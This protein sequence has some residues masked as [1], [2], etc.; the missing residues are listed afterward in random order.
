M[1]LGNIRVFWFFLEC[2]VI[3]SQTYFV[4]IRSLLCLSA[5]KVLC[6]TSA[7]YW[8][9]SKFQ[10][11]VFLFDG[12]KMIISYKRF[13]SYQY[14]T[15]VKIKKV[16]KLTFA[17]ADY[18]CIV[19]RIRNILVLLIRSTT[20]RKNTKHFRT[21]IHLIMNN[22]ALNTSFILFSLFLVIL[23]SVI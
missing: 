9:F 5:V 4:N 13:I 3:T 15:T 19:L 11:S 7:I 10:N 8:L 18:L 22:T 6:N 20:F 1:Q 2:F 17:L 12:E 16:K 14:N 23:F 21:K